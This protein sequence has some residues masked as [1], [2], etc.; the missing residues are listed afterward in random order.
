MAWDPDDISVRELALRAVK[1]ALQADGSPASVVTRSKVD[2]IR[3]EDLPC[4]DVTPDSSKQ[5]STFEDHD[6]T[7]VSLPVTVRGIIDATDEDDGALDPFYLFAVRRLCADLTLG[8]TVDSITWDGLVHVFRPDGRD[9]LGVELSF[10]LK[11]A[12]SRSDPAQKG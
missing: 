8:G 4:Y 1:A 12:V 10:E 3:S 7:G 11:F 6:C 9:I 2:Q 5:D